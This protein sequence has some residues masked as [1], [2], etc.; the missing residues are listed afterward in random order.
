YLE[1]SAVDIDAIAPGA[2]GP[3]GVFGKEF[4]AATIALHTYY[5]FC[6]LASHCLRF[7]TAVVHRTF[8]RPATVVSVEF[9]PHPLGI[10]ATPV[11]TPVIPPSIERARKF[12]A[13]DLTDNINEVS[14]ISNIMTDRSFH[15]ARSQRH[16]NLKNDYRRRRSDPD[17]E[18]YATSG[19]PRV[20]LTA[21]FDGVPDSEQGHD[22]LLITTK[23]NRPL[24]IS[25][26]HDYDH[27]PGYP[28]EI[29]EKYRD[30]LWDGSDDYDDVTVLATPTP[31]ASSTFK[32]FLQV[33]FWWNMV[34]IRI[35]EEIPHVLLSSTLGVLPN[36][37]DDMVSVQWLLQRIPHII[38][39]EHPLVNTPFTPE[40]SG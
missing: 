16:A 30:L 15:N 10:D 1:P 7:A 14:Q 17:I 27:A 34:L 19:T 5:P 39:K 24:P 23:L 29:S 26:Q 9:Q 32:L 12:P 13:L 40:Q 6:N 2:S 25:L 31:N 20:A 18:V 37:W 21:N 36:L 35:R 4:Y 8:S 11:P 28:E 22:G 38:W 33:T 3:G